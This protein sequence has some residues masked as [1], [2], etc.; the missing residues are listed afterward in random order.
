MTTGWRVPHSSWP[1]ELGFQ[2]LPCLCQGCLPQLLFPKSLLWRRTVLEVLT[3]V[4]LP[5]SKVL[6]AKYH[7]LKNPRASIGYSRSTRKGKQAFILEFYSEQKKDKCIEYTG[8]E[9]P[10]R[11]GE[12]C[13]R[14]DGRLW[15]FP[16]WNSPLWRLGS[17]H[18]NEGSLVWSIFKSGPGLGC[19]VQGLVNFDV[20]SAQS[21]Y[22]LSIFRTWGQL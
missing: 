15:R 13:L 16:L 14:G 4:W 10:A 5:N 11:Q 21:H 20:A 12:K 18:T 2:S 9:Q 6:L 22:V 19:V 7:L 8:R 1:L 3:C 17:R